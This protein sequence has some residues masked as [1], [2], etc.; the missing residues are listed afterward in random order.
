VAAASI[1]QLTDAD[2]PTYEGDRVRLAGGVDLPSTVMSFILRGV[3]LQGIDSVMAPK[4]TRE[5][6]W[7]RLATDLPIGMLN[8][9]TEI[10]IGIGI[11]I[12]PS[13]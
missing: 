8:A 1:E 7:A 11:G 10:G 2:L 12:T 4:A 5:A 13:R 3:R 9:M 6:A